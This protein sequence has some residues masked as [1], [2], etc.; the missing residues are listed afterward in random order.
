MKRV[1]AAIWAVSRAVAVTYLLVLLGMTFLE[2]WLV[3]PA[4]PVEWGDWSPPGEDYE[5]VWIEVP[6]ASSGGDS[7]RV[8]GWLFEK[9]SAPNA[10]LYCHGNG[11]DVSDQPD[12]ARLLRDRLDASVLVFDW[13]GYGKSEGR[14]HEAGVIA[15]GLAAQR[16][17]ADRVGKSPDQ[18]LLVGRSLG[19]GVA[20][21]LASREGASALVLQSTFTSLPDAA[22]K[23]YPF[24][25]VRWAMQNRFDSLRALSDYGGPVFISHGTHDTV[26]PFGHGERLHEAAVGPKAFFPLEGYG[27]NRP[28]PESYYDAL[29]DFLADN[30]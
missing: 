9:P 5:D 12:L 26:V 3:Y 22:A 8:H 2:R 21:A 13:R 11:E 6:S 14:P 30:R 1:G 10:V 24:L 4:P 27:H 16:W 7:S 17:L 20:T 19:G 29:R 15:D 23:H 25:P 18:L 28:Q